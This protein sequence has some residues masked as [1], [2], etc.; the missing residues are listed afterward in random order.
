MLP[1]QLYGLFWKASQH[2]SVPESASVDPRDTK[3]DEMYIWSFPSCVNQSRKIRA[4]I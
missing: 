1:S 2:V 3:I 4:Y